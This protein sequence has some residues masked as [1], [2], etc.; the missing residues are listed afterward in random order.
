MAASVTKKRRFARLRRVNKG[1]VFAFV[2]VVAV[3]LVGRAAIAR[4][5]DPQQPFVRA[6]PEVNEAI[7][8]L[9]AGDP[10]AAELILERYLETGAC[11]GDSGLH[12]SSKVRTRPDGT[13]DLGL[14]LFELG[15][16]YGKP[17]GKEE[18][19]RGASEPA[20]PPSASA[21]PGAEPPA[22]DAAVSEERKQAIDCALVVVLAIAAD[23]E[24]AAELRARA[25]FLAGNL[26][27]LRGQYEEAVRHYDDALLLFPGVPESE[28][29]DGIGRDIAHNRA[30][31]LRRLAAR[32]EQ[33]QDEQQDEKKDDEQ[34][35]EDEQKDE[36]KD[37]EQKPEDEQ[38]EP[39]NPEDQEDEKKQEPP[40][41]PNE[42]KDGEP[43]DEPK[44]P[45]AADEPKEPAGDES[46]PDA[47]DPD[48]E[49][50]AEAEPPDG[51]EDA[52]SESARK[53]S[54]RMLDELR[55]A[56]TYQEENAK[57]EALR[58]RRGQSMED[59]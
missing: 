16:K 55:E 59:K 46:K 48:R 43:K 12:I 7:A 29:G 3:A 49:K 27:A 53:P 23:R 50:T 42:P 30:I 26:E 8:K 57:R 36:K 14:A 33:K 31:L 11:S 56:P 44:E 9:R 2:L 21:Q 20:P 54:S 39:K 52:P 32:D 25:Y 47:G 24:V 45:S 18:P 10:E 19:E 40:S 37:D 6:A 41:E 15:E 38:K 28:P 22:P 1:L 5:W 17:F 51:E 13:F 34:K 4:G 58:G 35:P